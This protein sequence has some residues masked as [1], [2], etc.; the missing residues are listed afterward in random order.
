[1]N[2]QKQQS[3]DQAKHT[4]W[5]NALYETELMLCSR[6]ALKLTV[7]QWGNPGHSNQ[8]LFW[9]LENVTVLNES[10]DSTPHMS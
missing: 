9:S 3:A 4:P 10:Q 1:M 6:Q 5:G 7:L 8:D 2:F